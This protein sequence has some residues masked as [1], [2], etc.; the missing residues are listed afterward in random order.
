MCVGVGGVVG[1]MVAIPAMGR[2]SP[3]PSTAAATRIAPW[4]ARWFGSKI[5]SGIGLEA[6]GVVESMGKA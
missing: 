6:M 3:P 4:A 5:S 2:A 1:L